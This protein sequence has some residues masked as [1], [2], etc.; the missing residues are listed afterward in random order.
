MGQFTV[1]ITD[2]SFQSEVMEAN[3]LVM[4]DFWAV[5]CMPCKAIAPILEDLGE[6]Y[7]DKV[8]IGKVDV[9]NNPEVAS[10]YGIRSI[11]TLM[12]FKNGELVDKFVGAGP[13]NVYVD[14]IEKHL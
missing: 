9:D 7:K 10:Q 8:K 3:E 14:L 2:Q 11:P 1:E 12:L 13:K 4:V 5:W 6:S